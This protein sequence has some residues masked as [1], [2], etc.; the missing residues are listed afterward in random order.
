[1]PLTPEEEL[2]LQQLE[3]EEKAAT[4][5]TASGFSLGLGYIKDPKQAAELSASIGKQQKEYLEALPSA[6]V[7]G[8]ANLPMNALKGLGGLLKRGG[9]KLQQAAVG[10]KKYIPGVGETLIEEGVRGTKGGMAKKTAEQ[11]AKREA[12][13]QAAVKA[14]QG[15]VMPE[16]AGEAVGRVGNKASV[17]GNAVDTPFVREAGKANRRIEQIYAK[18]PQSAEE[19]LQQ[20]RLLGKKAYKP[21][22]GGRTLLPQESAKNT[23]DSELMRAE[24]KALK[25]G[26]QELA[27][28]EGQVGVAP[29]LQKESAL[30]KAQSALQ[31]PDSVQSYMPSLR[32]LLVSGAGTAVGGPIGGAAAYGAKKALEQP[33]VQ[34][35]TAKGLHTAGRGLQSP[36][37]SG[38]E[39]LIGGAGTPHIAGTPS[40]GLSPEEEAELQ[41][42]EAELGGR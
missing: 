6:L 35:Y 17:V 8:G 24:A 27:E 32:D 33:I 16:V 25:Q 41:Q 18:G 2:E 31:R 13:T 30:I 39:R 11:L 5:P 28:R 37:A 34:S 23:F 1:M 15:K 36:V 40:S 9:G 26:V 4:Q 21:D 29:L 42:L 7:G 12:E 14:I 38:I 22:V 3:A 10:M 19:A 20:S